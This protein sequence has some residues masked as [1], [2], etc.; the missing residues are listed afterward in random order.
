MTQKDLHDL[1]HLSVLANIQSILAPR[2][3]LFWPLIVPDEGVGTA[4]S[5]KPLSAVDHHNHLGAWLESSLS[6]DYHINYI[7]A[8]ANKGL[9]LIRR[10]FGFNNSEGVSTAY[11]TLVRP[12]LNMVVR[13]GM[14]I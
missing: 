8:K 2:G 11:K 7:C 14:R 9:R 1:Y 5:T 10:T 4:Y 12:I 13:S 3:V 6:W